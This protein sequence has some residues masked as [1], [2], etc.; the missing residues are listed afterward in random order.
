MSKTPQTNKDWLKEITTVLEAA[1]LV[2]KE[3]EEEAAIEG[4]AENDLSERLFVAAP[5]LAMK[6]RNVD[7]KKRTDVVP[8]VF[9]SIAEMLETHPELK[10]KSN[11]V[12]VHAYLDTHLYLK[13][14]KKSKCE[15]II[16]YLESKQ[17]IEIRGVNVG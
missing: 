9:T 8:A 1:R 13:L 2:I 14:L 12:F 17:I 11:R 16:D 4:H 5:V 15:G 3:N 10:T 7:F 6:N